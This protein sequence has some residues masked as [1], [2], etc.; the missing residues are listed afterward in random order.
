LKRFVCLAVLAVLVILV[1]VLV[2]G[3]GKGGVVAEVNGVKITRE[4]LD[5]YARAQKLSDMINGLILVKA[6]KDKGLD[7]SDKALEKRID[8]LNLTNDLEYEIK[9]S[10]MTI[11]DVKMQLRAK[12]AMESLMADAM[13]SEIKDSDLK[14][15]YESKKEQFDLPE[16]VR[17]RAM[18]FTNRD[19]A[20]KAAKALSSGKNWFEVARDMKA[21]NE[22]KDFV[23]KSS[24]KL[25]QELSKAA[26]S[27]P[28]GKVTEPLNISATGKP[29]WF[30]MMPEGKLPSRK[31]SFDQ[32]K[33][34]L[35][36][37]ITS[38]QEVQQY[39]NFAQ[40]VQAEI[41]KARRNSK[42]EIYD[43]K[44]EAVADQFKR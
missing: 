33:D 13:K 22:F 7:V 31:L 6:A 16:R 34:Q 2:G 17:V 38:M 39:G 36:L 21:I 43:K 8:H 14:K 42:I 40:K 27:T 30:I 1:V 24:D 25:P 44:L 20:E 26:F 35:R 41:Q 15:F 28:Q 19:D 9:S 18:V 37:D 3:C 23:P 5:N 11:D 12:L 29:V 32:V 10:G 4:Q